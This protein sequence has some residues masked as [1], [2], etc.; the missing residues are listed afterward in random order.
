M[1]MDISPALK[2]PEQDI[3]FALKL[4]LQNQQFAGENIEFESDAELKGSYALEDGG[5][6]VRGRLNVKYVR[7]CSKCLCPVHASISC[8]FE[9]MFYTEPNPD[10]PNDLF[11]IEN[12]SIDMSAYAESLVFLEVPMTA[13]CRPDC[14]G[15]CPVCGTNLN[16]SQCSCGR[17]DTPSDTVKPFAALEDLLT[18][19]EEV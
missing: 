6:I 11:Q 12:Y 13:K 18:R 15:L 14:K 19:D 10:D 3:P 17:A 7:P 4:R 16:I 5:V 8:D 9:D 2:N 1:R